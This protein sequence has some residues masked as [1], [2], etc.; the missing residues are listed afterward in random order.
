MMANDLDSELLRDLTRHGS[1]TTPIVIEAD[2]QAIK[3]LDVE[4]YG[5]TRSA[6]CLTGH[7]STGHVLIIRPAR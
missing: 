2:E 5:L 3:K 6:L 4:K 7:T 1:R